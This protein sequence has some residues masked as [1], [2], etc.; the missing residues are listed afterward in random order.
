MRS[1]KKVSGKSMAF[2]SHPSKASVAAPAPAA[3]PTPAVSATSVSK[4]QGSYMARQEEDKKKDEERRKDIEAKRMADER[5]REEEATR[6]RREL[7]D[8]R[9]DGAWV[10]GLVSH[11]ESRVA[12]EVY[13]QAPRR[14]RVRCADRWAQMG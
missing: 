6:K 4:A 10:R 14:E 5:K 3:A 12:F 9:R 7:E 1:L 11:G 2:I 8:A 13:P